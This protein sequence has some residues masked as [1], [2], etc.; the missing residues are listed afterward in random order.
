MTWRYS[1]VREL[2]LRCCGT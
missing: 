1:I 2:F